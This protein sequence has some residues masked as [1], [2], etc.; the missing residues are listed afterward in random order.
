[1]INTESILAQ[2]KDNH[3]KLWAC[4]RHRFSVSEVRLGQKITCEE[5]GGQMGLT[6]IGSYIRGYIAAGKPSTDIWPAWNVLI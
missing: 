1:M 2:V 3:R 4:K 5:C 6:E